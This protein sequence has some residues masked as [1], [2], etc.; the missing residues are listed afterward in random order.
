MIGYG[1]KSSSLTVVA[2]P[3]PRLLLFYFIRYKIHLYLQ[4]LEPEAL[5][6]LRKDAFGHR[7]DSG[8]EEG[9]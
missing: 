1:A 8:Q 4:K 6:V 2:L 5:S 3:R 9:R 7:G